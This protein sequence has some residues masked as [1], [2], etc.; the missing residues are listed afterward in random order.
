MMSKQTNQMGQTCATED[1]IYARWAAMIEGLFVLA[2]RD[3]NAD[4]LT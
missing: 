1:R 2:P 3:Y 4:A